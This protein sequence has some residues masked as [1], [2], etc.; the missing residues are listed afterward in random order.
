MVNLTVFRYEYWPD[1][2]MEYQYVEYFGEV[3]ACGSYYASNLYKQNRV[4]WLFASVV[5]KAM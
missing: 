5:C 1:L 3:V 4:T 2:V